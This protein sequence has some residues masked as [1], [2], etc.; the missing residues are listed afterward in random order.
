MCVPALPILV[1]TVRPSP[2]GWR[3]DGDGDIR[4]G[5]R[6]CAC[7]AQSITRRGAG[8]APGPLVLLAEFQHRTRN[9]LA[10]VQAV[11]HQTRRTSASLEDF[12]TEFESR[13]RALGRVQ[14]LLAR[15]DHEI[16]DM[17]TLVE[18]Q[19][20]ALGGGRDLTD[21]IAIDGPTV[22]LPVR[23]LQALA[24]ALHEL[25]T[26]AVEYGALGQPAGRLAV[27]WGVE[28]QPDQRWITLDWRE[29]GVR[30]AAHG[31]PRRRGYG[32]DLGRAHG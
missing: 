7:S 23:S 15:A 31:L 4:P 8:H 14:G 16:I 18:S 20:A 10:V 27:T 2:Q 6:R 12:E 28:R 5:E 1:P 13:L 22:A 32:S 26:N 21:G 29:T 19:L 11:A 30:M 3:H 25:A 9:L 24:L 17:R